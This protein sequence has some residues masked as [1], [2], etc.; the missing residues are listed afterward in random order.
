MQELRMELEQLTDAIKR[1]AVYQNYRTQRESVKQEP[2]LQEKIDEYRMRNFELQ[3]S[4]QSEDLFDKIEVFSREYEKF[5]ENP[6][7][8]AF[9]DAELAF[10]RMMQ[11]IQLRITEAVDF[12]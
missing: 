1:T 2:G 3:N 5:R 11:E 6:K 7:V 10:C 12:E 9:L 8:N 4:E